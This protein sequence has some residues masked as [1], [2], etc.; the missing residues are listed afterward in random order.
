[1][2][3]KVKRHCQVCQQEF[4]K[5]DLYPL[6]LLRNNVFTLAEQK[7]PEITKDGFVCFPDL[8]KLTALHFEQ[9]LLKERGA[10]TEL[11]EEVINSLGKQDLLSENVNIEFDEGLTFGERV[12]DKIAKFGGSW[13]FIIFFMVV[14]VSWMAINSFQLLR[15]EP[16]DPYPFILLNLVLSCLAAIQAPIIM[17][18]QNRQSSKDRLSQESDYQINLKSE[19]QIRQLNTRLELF[20]KHHWQKMHELTRMQEE[21]MQE[22]D[23][24]S[25]NH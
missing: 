25:T 19:L 1:M 5:S 13:T 12:A 18:S 2:T 14:L 4:D 9:I 23:M 24:K 15:G 20:M 22:L 16:F 10:L 3:K 17:M 21:I 6:A 11:E 8:R 7:Y